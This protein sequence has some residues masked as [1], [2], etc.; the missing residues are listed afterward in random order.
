MPSM[1]NDMETAIILCKR[2]LQSWEVAL[3][4]AKIFGSFCYTRDCLAI[5]L[6][7]VEPRK[8]F[9]KESL[10]SCSILNVLCDP[11]INYPHRSSRKR[12]MMR[13]NPRL[14]TGFPEE[15]HRVL[16]QHGDLSRIS[17]NRKEKHAFRETGRN[18][19]LPKPTR[20]S[21]AIGSVGG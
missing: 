4:Y 18:F 12:L 21:S 6:K 16:I 8:D 19:P 11:N 14:E 9:F 5:R 3:L 1:N 15:E 2:S 20:P 10:R 17:P 7:Q 13:H